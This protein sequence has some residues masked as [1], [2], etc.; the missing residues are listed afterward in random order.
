MDLLIGLQLG[1]VSALQKCKWAR[2]CRTGKIELARCPDTRLKNV[3]HKMEFILRGEVA[4][5]RW[6][7]HFYLARDML[8]H[9]IAFHLPSTLVICAFNYFILAE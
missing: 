4:R 7:E 5:D 6:S 8:T 3:G 2:Q 1:L 9:A